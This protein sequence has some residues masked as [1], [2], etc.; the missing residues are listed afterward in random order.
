MFERFTERAR[1]VVVLSQDE[2]R[3]SGHGHI[4][5]EHV[6]LGLLR[7]EDGLAAKV[8]ASLGVTTGAV[9]EQ[10][11]AI[12]G[13]GDIVISGQIPFTAGTKKV[14]EL[15][16]REA[17]SLRHNY[18]GTEHLLLA[19]V[20][21]TAGA[22]VEILTSLNFDVATIR[23]LTLAAL[24]EST[25]ETPAVMHLAPPR[26]DR[27]S[28]K[29]M[30]SSLSIEALLDGLAETNPDAVPDVG[31][32]INAAA[33]TLTVGESIQAVTSAKEAAI[34]NEEFQ[35]AAALRDIERRLTGMINAVA[36]NWPRPDA[37]EG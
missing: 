2:A 19:L 21:Q 10:T 15:S 3:A 17:L 26:V 9:R 5:T 31:K 1:N 28:P 20:R 13:E 29:G 12:V 34:S 22:A 14:L 11:L 16:L 8:L 27:S 35:R 18:I 24:G 6:L 36:A 23:A 25:P 33:R 37:Q 32:L 30:V 7:V 4:G